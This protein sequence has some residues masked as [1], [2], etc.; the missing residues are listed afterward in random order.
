MSAFRTQ[1]RSPGP[2][3][4]CSPGE[5]RH[6]PTPLGL[7]TIG[8]LVALASPALQPTPVFDAFLPFIAAS[9][10]LVVLVVAGRSRLK[11][12]LRGIRLRWL[13]KVR[14]RHREQERPSGPSVDNSLRI[15]ARLQSQLEHEIQKQRTVPRAINVLVRRI[16]LELR[17]GFVAVVDEVDGTDFRVSNSRGLSDASHRLRLDPTLREALE[18]GPV[19]L[20]GRAL[21]RSALFESLA[22]GDR[23]RIHHGISL[24][25]ISPAPVSQ[26]LLTTELLPLA[27]DADERR[28]RL[29]ALCR[30][31]WNRQFEVPAASQASNISALSPP[32]NPFT[33]PSSQI[34]E[35][36]EGVRTSTGID[37]TSLFLLT[38]S[39]ALTLSPTVVVGGL[40]PPGVEQK[41][42]EQERRLGVALLAKGGF[43]RFDEA[44]LARLK[45][46]SLWN[47]A[48]GDRVVL[49]GQTIGVICATSSRSPA[50]SSAIRGL[51]QTASTEIT[52][53]FER[54]L[55]PPATKTPSPESKQISTAERTTP[56]PSSAANAAEKPTTV[57][58]WGSDFSIPTNIA[59][60]FLSVNAPARAEK[61]PAPNIEPQPSPVITPPVE[62]VIPPASP[63]DDGRLQFLANMTHE[64]R[65]PMTGI[66]GMTEI[67]LDTNLTDEQRRCLASVRSSSQS[68]L[69][70]VNDLLDFSK[71]EARG[72]EIERTEFSL[73]SL[74]R[75]ALLPMAVQARQ[76]GLEFHCETPSGLCDRWRGDPLRFRQVVTNLVS[77]ALKF[78]AKGEVNVRVAPFADSHLQ[79]SVSDTGPGI[80]ADR[81]QRIFQ[82]YAQ[83][84][85][86]TAR[87]H[88]G[89]GL[90][91][92][93]S[94]QLVELMD[95]KIWL[96]SEEGRG[97][98]F[99]FTVRLERVTDG[100]APVET[101]PDPPAASRLK[102]LVV[103]DHEIN[104]SV[105]RLKL[106]A[107]GHI[108]D[109]A[110]S[111]R[112]A[113]D[114]F[115]QWPFDLILMDVQMADL[116]G[117][118][119]ARAIRRRERPTGQ[120][121]PI[122]AL[123]SLADAEGRARCLEAGMDDVL[124]KPIE[125]LT[126]ETRFQKLL[127]GRE[128][129]DPDAR[130]TELTRPAPRSASNDSVPE[131]R[132]ARSRIHP[133][134]VKLRETFLPKFLEA[135]QGFISEIQS[136][137]ASDDFERV[138]RAAH[139]LNGS[140][141]TLGYDDLSRLAGLVES[142]ARKKQRASIA[143]LID[144]IVQGIEECRL[145]QP[146]ATASADSL[147]LVSTVSCQ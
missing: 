73:R 98:T 43:D 79:V 17:G 28:Q 76:K 103:D 123:T 1:P 97:S 135:S 59:A 58:A 102:V 144:Q 108:V 88:G 75:E 41:W 112:E 78:T 67:V 55:P 5:R 44:E 141:G 99:S 34:R 6:A 118:T 47:S 56:A 53:T 110:C 94:R 87:R 107:R 61:A 2:I 8:L 121:T 136:G 15:S 126:I 22:P 48:W 111:G 143:P 125:P 146:A 70:L 113:C 21:R 114:A 117:L 36:L 32:P 134:L 64:L 13:R 85:A 38:S 115:A 139:T 101:R 19:S 140:A 71:L 69:Q 130:S 14:R 95:G 129:P 33:S 131:D 86:S 80:P 106:E 37:R 127:S 124:L 54:M 46:G 65:A 11:R 10:I 92:P 90:G 89:T 72:L 137:F 24:I 100:A 142:F 9:M 27:P 93:I 120:R 50:D 128:S 57:A 119:A 29:A 66:L 116:D 83:A 132:P 12:A 63:T 109:V 26:W 7:A 122:F 91:L 35:V 133:H 82:A 39:G 23:R 20:A 68:L 138:R 30:M 105:A 3:A 96:E 104:R 16:S 81:H 40:L 52:R 31:A 18:H 49:R 147:P 4:S 25:P 45:I 84:D 60:A 51:I 42:R 145:G 62:A 77:N 74:L